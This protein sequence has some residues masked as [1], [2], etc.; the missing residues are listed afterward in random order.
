MM[1]L[2]DGAVSFE[3]LIAGSGMK[4]CHVGGWI[5]KDSSF[6]LSLTPFQLNL[7]A[8]CATPCPLSFRVVIVRLLGPMLRRKQAK[9]CCLGVERVG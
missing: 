6:E 8:Q 5:Q 9:R 2:D 7:I 3:F 4:E 1:G